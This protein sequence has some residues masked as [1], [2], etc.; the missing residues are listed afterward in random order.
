MK[1]VLEVRNL[2]L[3]SLFNHVDLAIHEK[4]WTVL[5]GTNCSGKTTLI[6]ILASIFPIS[7]TVLLEQEYF[8][9]IPL[10]KKQEKIAVFFSASS[11][12][13]A[14]NK[15]EEEIENAVKKGKDKTVSLKLIQEQI[16]AF[17]FSQLLKKKIEELSF[18][19]KERL[20]LLL[21]LLT[22]KKVVLLD[23]AFLSF[24]EKEKSILIEDFRRLKENGIAIFMTTSRLE[25]GIYAD[26][27]LVLDH[28]KIILDDI[29]HQ[30]YKEDS[31]LNKIGLQLPFFVDL[32]I[33][34][35]Y[36]NLIN[37]IYLKQEELV[38]ALWKSN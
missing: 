4:E 29:P 36:Y 17:D 23:D 13:F 20:F 7:K 1:T 34:L 30:V 22:R 14:Y 5:T 16:K 11:Y 28:G 32:S 31:L 12:F 24:N 10:S 19:Q 25:D 9:T 38:D 26:R 6:K 27:L 15:V 37:Q 33:K 8:D 3:S 2:N 18:F 21:S 35:Q